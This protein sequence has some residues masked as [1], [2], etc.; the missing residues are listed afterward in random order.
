MSN[1]ERGRG[2]GGQVPELWP[3]STA[4]SQRAGGRQVGR[5]VGKGEEKGT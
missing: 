4:A 1:G 3:Q 2:S 5:R